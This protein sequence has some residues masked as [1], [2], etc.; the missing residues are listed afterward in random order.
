MRRGLIA[1]S[2]DELP[3]TV[4]D[5]RVAALQTAMVAQGLDALVAYTTPARAAACATRT[6]PSTLTRASKAASATE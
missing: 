3:E 4:L 6:V 5:A 1:W 2:K